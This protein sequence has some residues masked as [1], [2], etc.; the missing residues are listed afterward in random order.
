MLPERSA[1]TKTLE[2]SLALLVLLLGGWAAR[3]W[4]VGYLH[5]PQ[6]SIMNN[7]RIIQNQKQLW[8]AD[9]KKTAEDTPTEAALVGYFNSGRIPRSV[10]GE[11]YRIN[12]IGKSPAAV[13][14]K[15]IRFERRTIEAGGEVTLDDAP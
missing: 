5:T 14:P 1:V 10:I 7:L 12:P 15:R 4:L 6:R 3:L 11:T 8:A 9:N 13:V 2:V